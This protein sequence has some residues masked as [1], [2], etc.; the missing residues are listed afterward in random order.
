[1]AH[2]KSPCQILHLGSKYQL[3][4]NSKRKIK[5]TTSSYEKG[6]EFCLRQC[7]LFPGECDQR[8]KSEEVGEGRGKKKGLRWSYVMELTMSTGSCLY[9]FRRPWRCCLKG[10][11]APIKGD[12]SSPLLPG[13]LGKSSPHGCLCCP[14]M[15]TKCTTIT[16]TPSHSRVRRQKAKSRKSGPEVGPTAPMGMG[17]HPTEWDAAGIRER[18]VIPLKWVTRAITHIPSFSILSQSF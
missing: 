5:Y 7:N 6:F 18:W 4:E 11:S 12:S 1:M 17:W 14:C 10:V 13:P 3:Q 2:N 9:N 8:G 16:A 15:S